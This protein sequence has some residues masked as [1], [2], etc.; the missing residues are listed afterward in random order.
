MIQRLRIMLS[1]TYDKWKTEFE[2]SLSWYYS[3]QF[4]KAQTYFFEFYPV[5]IHRCSRERLY[6]NHFPTCRGAK[7]L[8]GKNGSPRLETSGGKSGERKGRGGEFTIQR[9]ARNFYQDPSLFFL[10]CVDPVLV[11]ERYEFSRKDNERGEADLRTRIKI[12]QMVATED[13]QVR[14]E[15][16]RD[17][18]RRSTP[19]SRQEKFGGLNGTCRPRRRTRVKCLVETDRRER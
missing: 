8:N 4:F 13:I 2:D 19:P 5:D 6:I 11:R 9:W 7:R 1:F 16:K 18:T 15:R 17:H 12:R 3:I 10:S 14:G